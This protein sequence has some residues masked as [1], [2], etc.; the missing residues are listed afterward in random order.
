[1]A[2]A[3]VVGSEAGVIERSLELNCAFGNFFWPISAV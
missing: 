1:M 3:K 2:M